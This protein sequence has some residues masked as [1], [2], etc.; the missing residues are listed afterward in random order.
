MLRLLSLALLV[1]S[2]CSAAW[3]SWLT[4]HRVLKAEEI[5]ACAASAAD[6]LT[7]Y[8]GV[9]LGGHEENPL[10]IKPGT[11][12]RINWPVLIT[13]KS[14]ICALPFVLEVAAHQSTGH[15]KAADAVALSISSTS[16]ATFSWAAY[17]NW[18]QIAV[19]RRINAAL[20]A[21]K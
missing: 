14:I 17:H 16:A 18:G 21:G 2:M 6:G 3:P 8:K 5:Y 4:R 11:G 12:G 7:T 9:E 19:Q 10:F 15:E 13:Y 1:C 20:A